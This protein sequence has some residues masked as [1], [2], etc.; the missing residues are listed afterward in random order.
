MV[1]LTSLIRKFT[2]FDLYKHQKA[3]AGSILGKLIASDPS[4]K[5]NIP[6][7]MNAIEKT[8]KEIQKLP[9]AAIEQ[10]LTR[11]YPELLEKKEEKER[12][13][14]PLANVHGKVVMRFAPYPSGPLHI[15]NARPA[16]LN[17]A[18]V[19]Q[20]NGTFLL[21]M[22]DT[23]GSE[24][25]NITAEAYD[26]IPESLTWL[27]VHYD[28]QILYKSDRLQLYYDHAER[29]IKKD[30]AYIC[31]CSSEILRA[32]RAAGKECACRNASVAQTLKLWK[33]MFTAIE[34]SCS[35]RIKTSLQDKNPAFR[36]RVIFRISD[37]EHPRVKKKYRV[38]PLL[39]FSWAVDDHLLGITHILR[40]KDLMIESDMERYIWNIFGWPERE[41]IHTGL[42]QVEG[43]KISKSKSKQEVLSGQYTGWDDP[44]TWSFQALRRRGI[45]PEALRTFCLNLGVTQTE[46]TVP[47]EA[48]YSE[49]KKIIEKTANRYFFVE[50]PQKI[51]IK[52]APALTAQLP[53]HP[54]FKDRG[55]R[56]LKTTDTFYIQDD[57]ET[58]KA[59]RLMHLFNFKDMTYLS[60]D[61][62][63]KL[64]ARMIHWLPAVDNT[65]SVEILMPD[66]T[67]KKGMGEPTLT[68]VKEHDV[69]QFERFGFCRLDKKTKEK[70]T[71]WFTHR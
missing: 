46:I 37:R 33:E 67:W 57:L 48:L 35:L 49:N 41:I 12:T 38:W 54:D 8:I 7:V 4:V 3:N 36:D 58:G 60:Q 17:D 66:G 47:I 11:D 50:H 15:G 28:P 56:T 6:Q 53:L 22:D 5:K 40:G 19:K 20:Y 63:E 61:I 31:F 59:Y 55:T 30:K 1:D 69:I 52:K 68:N 25:K 14:P 39:D 18:Y 24:E 13:L 65:P 21:V 64:Q 9:A 51:V 16:V 62:D 32:N 23:I 27:G 10:E 2:L 70:M 26:L 34:G 43:A 71:F 45:L 29:L 42:F 44:R